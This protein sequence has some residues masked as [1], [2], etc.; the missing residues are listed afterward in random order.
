MGQFL[1][2]IIISIKLDTK[3]IILH[4]TISLHNNLLAKYYCNYYSKEKIKIQ[5][6]YVPSIQLLRGRVSI[7]DKNVGIN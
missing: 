1:E 6:N 7:R 2:L 5:R 4:E 3:E